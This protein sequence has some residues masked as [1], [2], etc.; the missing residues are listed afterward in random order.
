MNSNSGDVSRGRVLIVDDEAALRRAY[1]RL[2]ERDGYEVVMAAD[3]RAATRELERASTLDAVVS[4]IRMPEMSGLELLRSV[5]KLDE[6]LPVILVTANPDLASALEAIDHGA[7]KYLTKPVDGALL[8][9][10]VERA[11]TLRRMGRLKREALTVLG[12]DALQTADRATL[13]ASFNGALSTLWMAYQPIVSA[14]DGQIYG[15]EALLRTGEPTLPH[16]GAVI[17]AAERLGRLE[18]LGRNIRAAAPVPMGTGGAATLFLN[19]HPHDLRDETLFAANSP[20]GRIA[21][22]VVLEITER[23]SLGDVPDV[24][25]RL[26]RLRRMGFRLAVDDLGAGYAGLNS[27]ATLEPEI[28][29]L[30]MSLVRDIDSNS[31]KRAVVDKMTSLAHTLEALVV[32]EGVETVAER[33]ALVAV[34][35]DLM[36][37]YLFARPG[38]PFPSATWGSDPSART[39]RLAIAPASARPMPTAAVR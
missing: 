4:D 1:A 13:A 14:N 35:C 22:R 26:V 30:D 32:A 7:Y 11:V 16:P 24:R 6:D 27:F 12:R 19:L 37:G 21:L 38:R 31:I 5:R 36:Q 18:E 15:Y 20:L 25:D 2:L 17:E 10:N 34:G 9:M 28:V 29:K 8:A 39:P 33:D 3:G 23:A